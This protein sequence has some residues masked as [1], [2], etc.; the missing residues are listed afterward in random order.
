M[1]TVTIAGAKAHLVRLLA[2]VEAG[3]TVIITRAGRALAALRP[4]DPPPVQRRMGFLAGAFRIPP[5]FDRM[6]QTEIAA[7]F[8]V[9][10]V[11]RP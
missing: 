3:E 11:R 6:G 8:G 5:D 1:H 4:V 10:P 2:R 9:S 7:R